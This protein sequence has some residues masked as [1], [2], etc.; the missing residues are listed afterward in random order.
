MGFNFGSAL[1]GGAAGAGM[2]A[3]GGPWGA[4][5]GGVLGLLGGGFGGKGK[6]DQFR[7]IETMSPQQKQILSHL[8]QM[9]GPEGQMG[10]AYGQ[11]LG[12]LQEMMDPSSAAYQRFEAPHL[13]QFEQQTIPGLAERF[14]GAGPM[15]GALSSSGFGQ[16]LGAAGSQLQTNL[17]GMKAGLQQQ[18]I[19]DILQQYQGMTGQALSA[20]PFGYTYQPGSPS[21]GQSMLTSWAGQG[22]PGLEQAGNKLSEWW[23]KKPQAQGTQWGGTPIV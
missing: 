2:G 21:F 17:A 1:S 12:G 6:K 10:Q 18:A 14:A 16:S 20:K 9:L 13:Q 15:G 7:Q 8:A 3:V 23:N 22:M 11:G 19:R 4:A 5:I